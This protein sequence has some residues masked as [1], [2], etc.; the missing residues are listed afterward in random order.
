MYCDVGGK[1]VSFGFFLLLPR[2][3]ANANEM[4]NTFATSQV[5]ALI[6]LIRN[7]WIWYV[8]CSIDLRLWEYSSTSSACWL[9]CENEFW[10]TNSQIYFHIYRLVKCKLVCQHI[11][12]VDHTFVS[13][14]SM[15]ERWQS[16]CKHEHSVVVVVV[17]GRQSWTLPCKFACM[18]EGFQFRQ[19]W[20][21]IHPFGSSP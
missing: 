4:L 17:V 21:Y 18:C 15:M 14:I 13:S 3:V 9:Y 19:S 2:L 12:Y 5:R 1:C 8:E 20:F 11:Y 7:Y 16:R 6:S 10:W